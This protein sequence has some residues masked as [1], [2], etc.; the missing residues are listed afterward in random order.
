MTRQT[1]I[2]I[3]TDSV[4]FLR[5]RNSARAW[6]PFCNAESEIVALESIQVVSNLDRG[7]LE[8][9]INSSELHRLQGEDGTHLV[10]LNSLLARMQKPRPDDFT[11]NRR[12]K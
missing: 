1:R 2:T 5:G 12:S 3:E 11:H 7:E 10:C 6:C 9:W 4:L 8:Q